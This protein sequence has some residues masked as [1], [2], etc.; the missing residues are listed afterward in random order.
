MTATSSSA[1]LVDDASTDPHSAQLGTWNRVEGAGPVIR[2][3][4]HIGHGKSEEQAML[5][6]S[7]PGPRGTALLGRISPTADCAI[8]GARRLGRSSGCGGHGSASQASAR[9]QAGQRRQLPSAL[10]VE[11]LRGEGD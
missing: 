8:A 1:G 6:T 9:P 3:L 4:S 2:Q 11:R 5:P 7:Q 10:H